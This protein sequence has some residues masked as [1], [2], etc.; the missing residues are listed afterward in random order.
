[1]S[2]LVISE[3]LAKAGQTDELLAK[4]KKNLPDT[5]GAEGCEG[6]E[7]FVDQDVP[8]RVILISRVGVSR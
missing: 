1:M 6:M 4:L 5:R 7:T 3:Y 2:I 8:G